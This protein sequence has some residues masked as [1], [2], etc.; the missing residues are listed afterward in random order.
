[1]ALKDF[2]NKAKETAILAKDKAVQVAN[3]AVQA[4]KDYKQMSD[5]ATA[6]A[7]NWRS[8]NPDLLAAVLHDKPAEAASIY[9]QDT[10]AT[11]QKADLVIKKITDEVKQRYPGILL[12]QKQ[13]EDLES[14]ADKWPFGDKQIPVVVLFSPTMF[15]VSHLKL[16]ATG[17]GDFKVEFGR[18]NKFDT[19]S[20]IFKGDH[21]YFKRD[22]DGLVLEVNSFSFTFEEK[23]CTFN[24]DDKAYVDSLNLYNTFLGALN[25][26]MSLYEQRDVNQVIDGNMSLDTLQSIANSYKFKLED[27]YLYAEGCNIGEIVKDMLFGSMKIDS[28]KNG[29]ELRLFQRKDVYDYIDRYGLEQS[30]FAIGARR[31][32]EN[33]LQQLPHIEESEKW[34]GNDS[35]GNSVIDVDYFNASIAPALMVYDCLSKFIKLNRIPVYSNQIHLIEDGPTCSTIFTIKDTFYDSYEYSVGTDIQVANLKESIHEYLRACLKTIRILYVAGRTRFYLSIYLPDEFDYPKF[36]YS[37][38]TPAFLEALNSDD[39]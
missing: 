38:L 25:P 35:Q 24:P 6:E 34:F 1:M 36:E 14:I 15:E 33:M 16:W 7:A 28:M 2:L 37:G 29:L 23:Y 10:G 19:Y 32:A 22:S 26:S 9:M 11:Q 12:K 21:I 13:D 20:A 17:M 18:N 8:F 27:G 39:E 3:N 5:E 31:Q 4:A 30:F